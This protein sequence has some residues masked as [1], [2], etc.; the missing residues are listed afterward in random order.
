[1][2]GRMRYPHYHLAR[3]EGKVGA[4]TKITILIWNQDLLKEV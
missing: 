1:M 3:Q 4:R 2:A